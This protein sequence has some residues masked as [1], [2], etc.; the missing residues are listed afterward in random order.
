[1]TLLDK[2]E[3]SIIIAAYNAQTCIAKAIQSV[4]KQTINDWELIVVDDGSTDE[5]VKIV[6]A[7]AKCDD[8]IKLYENRKNL[9]VAKSRNVG[10]K[11]SHGNAV[12]FLD[13]DDS[14]YPEKLKKQLEYLRKENADIIYTSYAIVDAEGQKR[15]RDYI[16][17]ESIT[18]EQ[19]LETNVIGCSTV[20]LRKSVMKEC[21][22]LEDYFHEDYVLWLQLLRSGCK[23]V[24]IPEVL[25]DYYYHADS[26]AG[27]KKRA[28]RKRWNIYRKYLGFSPAKSARYFAIYALSG[29]RKYKQVG[30]HL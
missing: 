24:G 16:V 30:K 7:F 26:K 12:A 11:L 25:V 18:F 20:M 1:M 22:F 29:L 13:S 3:V 9:G 21:G 6:T 4:Q 23:A 5:T 27:N 10:L 15:C 2:P 14:W 28:A 17:P 8:R 19:L